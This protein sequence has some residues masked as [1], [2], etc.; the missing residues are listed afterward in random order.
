[1]KLHNPNSKQ[2]RLRLQIEKAAA[3]ADWNRAVQ[4]ASSKLLKAEA[5]EKR[6]RDLS[7]EI[8]AF[9]KRVDE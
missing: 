7:A 2:K 9:N 8:D 5:A 4:Q 3:Y 1:M 6:F